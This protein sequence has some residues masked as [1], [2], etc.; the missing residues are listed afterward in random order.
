MSFIVLWYWVAISLGAI[1]GA[2]ARHFIQSLLNKNQVKPYG[3]LVVNTL[4]CF[5][6]GIMTE[7]PVGYIQHFFYQLITIGFCAS[8]TTFSSFVLEIYFMLHMG[9]YIKG[10]NYVLSSVF[11]GLM[12]I[13]V[14]KYLSYM[15]FQF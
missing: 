3:T 10:I 9:F 2:I 12:A 7:I 14:G 1:T 15:I 8:F 5:I 4:G 13:C 11:I 6:I